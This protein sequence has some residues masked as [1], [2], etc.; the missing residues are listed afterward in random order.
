MQHRE[1]YLEIQPSGVKATWHYRFILNGKI[2]MFALGEHPSVR[3]A[4]ARE[5]CG[6]ACKLVK[7]GINPAQ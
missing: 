1:L 2:S 5:R 3:L 4:E 7:Q 6:T